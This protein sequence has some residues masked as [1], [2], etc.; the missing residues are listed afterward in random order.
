MDVSTLSLIV[1]V[2]AVVVGPY[3][4]LI[5]ARRQIRASLEAADKQITAPMRQAWIN[6]L[7][8]LLAELI[9]S[10]LHYYVA[11]FED[12]TDEEYQRVTLLQAHIQL[13]L[14]PNE[15]DHQ[16]LGVLMGRMVNEIQYEKGK[17][18]EFPD[19]HIEVSALS[20]KIL[21][22]EWDRVKNPIDTRSVGVLE[23]FGPC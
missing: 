5:I 22:R 21:K 11:G 14:N 2:L 12:R 23:R 15:E 9:S 18:D 19:L 10:A 3:V 4:S 20:Q 7:R 8:E 13:M 1:A 17:K 6:K 16:R